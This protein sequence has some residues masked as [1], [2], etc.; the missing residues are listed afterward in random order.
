[1]LTLDFKKKQVATASSLGS[2]TLKR[3]H[4]NYITSF[5]PQ[6]GVGLVPCNGRSML[7]TSVHDHAIEKRE[8][9]R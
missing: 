5:A 2:T 6:L 4:I 9:E 8:I 7:K 1:V 3:I